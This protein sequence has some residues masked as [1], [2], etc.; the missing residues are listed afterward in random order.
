MDYFGDPTKGL[1]IWSFQEVNS[2]DQHSY[3]AKGRLF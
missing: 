3:D 1:N 2:L